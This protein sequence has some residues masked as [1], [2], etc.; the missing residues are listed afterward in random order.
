MTTHR[1]FVA[2]PWRIPA[3]VY[4]YFRELLFRHAVQVTLYSVYFMYAI[5]QYIQHINTVHQ[6]GAKTVSTIRKIHTSL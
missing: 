2:D 6:L 1:Y 5:P 4:A 3:E